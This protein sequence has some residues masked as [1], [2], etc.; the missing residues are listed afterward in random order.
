[1]SGDHPTVAEGKVVRKACYEYKGD[2]CFKSNN[3]EVVN[4]GE[5]YYVYK[6]SPSPSCN[7]RYCGSDD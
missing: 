5:Q 1:M 4:C 3:I 7:L 6:L 2:C